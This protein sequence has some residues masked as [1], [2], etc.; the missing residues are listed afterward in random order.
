MTVIFISIFAL[1][2]CVLLSVINNFQGK[3]DGVS[4]FRK[5]LYKFNKFDRL[6]ENLD[7]LLF[8][9]ETKQSTNLICSNIG[10]IA[11]ISFSAAKDPE[12]RSA[13]ISKNTWNKIYELC[14][15]AVDENINISDAEAFYNF[16]K[17][18]FDLNCLNIYQ[19]YAVPVAL[20]IALINK[21]Y[22][23]V[24]EL[25]HKQTK[26]R[27][28]ISL[29]GRCGFNAVRDEAMS[30][31]EQMYNLLTLQ[32]LNKN[33]YG[34][35]IS[36]AAL[37]HGISVDEIR[38][39]HRNENFKLNNEICKLFNSVIKPV[40]DVEDIIKLLDNDKLLT[41]IDR[42]YRISNESTRK[43]YRSW[44][45]TISKKS[46]TSE[47]A[48]LLA[49]KEF[50]DT[51][52]KDNIGA[53]Y[54]LF[55]CGQKE[56]FYKL[57]C[58]INTINK[59]K[60]LNKIIYFTA[61]FASILLIYSVIFNI[62]ASF[63]IGYSFLL[64]VFTLPCVLYLSKVISDN[65]I[66]PFCESAFIPSVDEK[67]ISNEMSL[68][69]AVPC[70][71]TGIEK[72]N[73]M[74]KKLEM[75]RLSN[76]GCCYTL[77][78]DFPP[79]FSDNE[80]KKLIISC[81]TNKINDLNQKYGESFAFVARE[82]SNING[83]KMPK[84]RKRGALAALCHA[85]NGADVF[86]YQCGVQCVRGKKYVFTIDEDTVLTPGVVKKLY[87][88]IIHPENI[89][90]NEKRWM[91]QP[92][93]LTG[94]PY[95]KET[96]F[97]KWYLNGGLLPSYP[98]VFGGVS[99]RIFNKSPFGGKGIFEVNEYIK[100]YEK[101]PQNRVLSHD[102]PE[103]DLMNCLTDESAI[104]VENIPQDAN[105]FF[106]RE[107]RW[108]RGDWQ[109]LFYLF[110]KKDFS[111]AFN[112]YC[113]TNCINSIK[114]LFICGS[115][116]VTALFF[117]D[118]LFNLV[119]ILSALISVD[120]LFCL[121]KC[122]FDCMT[123]KNHNFHDFKNSVK[124]LLVY[125]LLLPCKAA[126]SFD[127][128]SKTIIRVCITKKN[129]LQ[130][131][132]R[133][134]VKQDNYFTQYWAA[135][136]FGLLIA[137]F[138]L[139]NNANYILSFTLGVFYIV[140]PIIYRWLAKTVAVKQCI[141][142]QDKKDDLM[143][144]AAKTL[145][146]YIDGMNK[147]TNY[148]VPDN[149]Q[150]YP[151]KGYCRRTSITN[152]GFSVLG[153]ACGVKMGLLP[154]KYAYDL[155]CN[156]VSSIEKLKTYNNC[157]YN[158]YDIYSA[159]P[160]GG[161]ISTVDSG[162]FAAC[163]I[164]AAELLKQCKNKEDFDSETAK[165]LKIIFYYLAEDENRPNVKYLSDLNVS[166]IKEFLYNFNEL[167]IYSDSVKEIIT[168]W[169]AALY[170]KCYDFNDLPDRLTALAL[171]EEL[172]F[173]YNKDKKLFHI[174]Y[175]TLNN[176]YTESH[177]DLFSSENLLT[178]FWAICTNK[179]PIDHWYELSRKRIRSHGKCVTLSWSGTMFETFMPLIF[180][181]VSKETLLYNS[182]I[183]V[184]E[185]NIEF[186]SKNGF[187]FGVSE[188]CSGDINSNGDFCYEAHGIDELAL[189]TKYNHPIFS[190]YA[191]LMALDFNADIVY[192]NVVKF[193][194]MGMVDKFG[195]FESLDCRYDPP[196]IARC[197]MAHHQGMILA[198]LCNYI[199]NGAVRNSF[200]NCSHMN[201]SKLI[202]F[203]QPNQP[204]RKT[205]KNPLINAD[206]NVVYSEVS[207]ARIFCGRCAVD[208]TRD[209]FSVYYDDITA[210]PQAFTH[211]EKGGRF[212]FY[213]SER[214]YPIRWYKIL[215]SVGI[216]ECYAKVGNVEIKCKIMATLC[217][218]TM[219]M[220]LSFCGDIPT[221]AKFVIGADVML[222]KE[223]RYYAHPQ[224][225]NLFVQNE[226]MQDGALAYISRYNGRLSCAIGISCDTVADYFT[227]ADSFYLRNGVYSISPKN[228]SQQYTDAVEPFIGF[229]TK[230]HDKNRKIRVILAAGDTKEQVQ[231]SLSKKYGDINEVCL[232]AQELSREFITEKGMGAVAQ[233]NYLKLVQ[234]L[235]L[236]TESCKSTDFNNDLFYKLGISGEN[237]VIVIKVVSNDVSDLRAVLSHISNFAVI[238]TDIII[239][240]ESVENNL[241]HQLNTIA[242]EERSGKIENIAVASQDADEYT[243]VAFAVINTDLT[244]CLNEIKPIQQPIS[245]E[246][247]QSYI[248]CD[249]HFNNDGFYI[250]N[251]TIKPWC[252]VLTNGN[253]GTIVAENGASNT[254]GNNA[255]LVKYTH[256][257]SDYIRNIPT[258]ILYIKN[259]DNQVWTVTASPINRGDHHAVLHSF[260][261]TKYYYAGFNI[262]AEQTVFIDNDKNIKYCVVKLYNT[263]Y[264]KQKLTV[265]YYVKAFIGEK[266]YRDTKRCLYSAGKDHA[267]CKRGDKK[268]YLQG[269]DVYGVC[270]K[271]FLGESYN[272]CNPGLSIED[273]S[274]PDCLC[275]IKTIE[276]DPNEE[277][278][279]CFII[280]D[281]LQYGYDPK[282]S[283]ANVINKHQN[284]L[285]SVS[286][287]IGNHDFDLFFSKWLPYQVLNS[288]F[289]ARCG[290]YQAGGA[291]GFRDQLQD[292]L[293]LM[294]YD[295]ELVRNHIVSCCE[296]QFEYGDVQHWW[297]S[298]TLGVRTEISDDR[299]WL[300]YVTC[301][302]IDFVGDDALFEQQAAYLVGGEPPK[303]AQYE[304]GVKTEYTQSVYEHCK[305]AIKVSMT[306]GKHDL[307][308]IGQGDWNDAMDEVGDNGIGESVW[309][310]W[311]ILAVSDLFI[312][313]VYKRND[314]EFASELV[315]YCTKLKSSLENFA[316][317]GDRY[318][319]AITDDGVEL[320]DQHS[321]ACKCDAI[322]QAWAVISGLCEQDRGRASVKAAYNTLYDRKNKVLSLF[323]PPFGPNT[324][325]AG[326]INDYP[327]GIR[328]NGGQ[329]THGA[330][331]LAK[332]LTMCGY[333]DEAWNVLKCCAPMFRN[334]NLLEQFGNEP[335]VISAD[336]YNDGRG[337]W[338]WYTGAAGWFFT[339]VIQNI[340]GINISGNTIKIC[341][342]FPSEISKAEVKIKIN[343][344]F[345]S[346]SYSN[347][348]NRPAGESKVYFEGRLTDVINCVN[349]GQEHKIKVIV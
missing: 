277:K 231:F 179:V 236:G 133:Q 128:V 223:N 184:L 109:N 213:D 188:S 284:Y 75:C 335:Y 177:Y 245:G 53:G 285:D 248:Q 191:S 121:V 235:I 220:D 113:F 72:C 329:Y 252:N 337:G 12:I 302:Y 93:V 304:N 14:I 84:E 228:N 77:V 181:D 141:L 31:S 270:S 117:Y 69:L 185:K 189:D 64:T 332:A 148:L 274:R 29:C 290:Y 202:L 314:K 286:V 76:W 196:K 35:I 9:P 108:I 2:L 149:Y 105:E 183:A 186:S 312:V 111:F 6:I 221:N 26:M 91:L 238:K 142:S 122:I 253:F 187:P 85:I 71:L 287:N 229:E 243:A 336:I 249:Q 254:F 308:L 154:Q 347:P 57:K 78:C 47:K 203:E 92:A 16:T 297:H 4:Y 38:A 124:R 20:K 193:T 180:F 279:I 22:A 283:F 135:P 24:K 11:D 33:E 8:L 263:S 130:W 294:Y 289:L 132:S 242:L 125:V 331:W 282:E 114:E 295:K 58:K 18:V 166:G 260:G 59:V 208:I 21:L 192:K 48:I 293:C 276:L 131:D 42:G 325:R 138:S 46:K 151:Y 316:W 264:K 120:T 348:F 56:L 152:I 206:N 27:R 107:H 96:L 115:V 343:N 313:H 291:Y 237:K 144:L 227:S 63:S 176:E 251:N 43:K 296:H 162:N 292:C 327:P 147:H 198:S 168:A 102:Q 257:L 175:D 17:D 73:T 87:C 338:S 97:S 134:T 116:L 301:K 255:A 219:I 303:G 70:L 247:E 272:L 145:C 250:T 172:Q 110:G 244:F 339:V 265:G 321:E 173:L 200:M 344:D 3:R 112:F 239:T 159:K 160:L 23:C 232:A 280:S 37:F 66:V 234:P 5:T 346:I 62:M 341:P 230:I 300:P 334:E 342:C 30:D 95:K 80:K 258:E 328:E 240:A 281:E 309:L 324:V 140:S 226:I 225:C 137:L 61:F 305:K 36:Q 182:A 41:S 104:C 195:M 217:D 330:V 167:D 256:V 170:E 174:G 119:L 60:K 322:T 246:F 13:Q 81:L 156:A 317:R 169:K 88:D 54:Y 266:Y 269:G 268:L 271:S 68:V 45:N 28:L 146:Y 98:A 311:F 333:A 214:Y 212:Y 345:Y 194:K 299:L 94:I 319:R 55:G 307:P 349:D 267:V 211:H 197:Y 103:G 52:Y 161:F 273:V 158:W 178:S 288:R 82:N 67:L 65:I 241:F 165:K 259:A 7:P 139:F 90:A 101:L 86:E 204:G 218:G 40:F 278:E 100:T 51:N 19:M 326:Y 275:C 224:F 233:N 34:D 210:I 163:L 99:E 50:I 127:A 143:V 164:T 39:K 209:T 79:D 15:K 10:R 310:A 298:D 25:K 153:I 32:H 136:F 1:A 207:A 126:I 205:V 318:I 129:L 320:G 49:V 150:Q 201:A 44:L 216:A 306:L 155:L 222:E 106:A 89:Y 171:N 157:H 315:E 74:A 118:K 199:N 340:L 323:Y 123:R 215:A 190:P 261:Y 83:A 262:D